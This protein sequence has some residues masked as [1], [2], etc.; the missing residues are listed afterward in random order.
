[1]AEAMM[2]ALPI[3]AP[4]MLA[5]FFGRGSLYTWAVGAPAA[6]HEM[7]STISWYFTAPFI[8][9]RLAVFLTTWML[10][11]VLM[12]RTSARADSS[13]DLI[14]HQRMVRYSAAFIGIFALSFSLATVDWL[15]SLDPRWTSTIF[16]V[17]VC[18]GLL[19][20]GVAAITLAVV[21]LHERGHLAD[22]VNE[23][24]LHDLGKLLFAFTTFWAYIWVSQYLLI[25]YGNLPEETS[26][27]AIRTDP[28]WVTA[29]LA[30]PIVNWLIPFVVLLPRASKRR[31]SVLKWVAVVLLL[32]RWL[33][34]YLL[35][36][37]QT[38]KA[39]A[40]GLLELS[41]AFAYGGLTWH[42]VAGALAR[43]PLV[44]RHDPYLYDCRRHHQ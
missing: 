43:R 18:S 20:E 38:M 1:V 31:P 37:P 28:S 13:A 10:F 5:L 42:V 22:V 24:H 26:H 40:F 35:V 36:A 11:A 6:E 3:A 17:Y 41:I 4:M 9:T 7:V 25:W 15:L 32:G 23:N 19:V 2:C 34:V 16:A 8:F 44:V 14:H 33:D 27:Y 30:N 29:F 21:V 39:P 12:R